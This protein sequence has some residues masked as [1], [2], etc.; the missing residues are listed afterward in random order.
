MKW[1]A[2]PLLMVAANALAAPFLVTDPLDP[3]ATSCGVYMDAAAKVTIPVGLDATGKPIC[4]YDLVSVAVGS[5]T[6]QLTAMDNDPIWG[7][8]ESAK[9][10]PF[11]F[12]RPG[13]LPI[14]ANSRLS[15]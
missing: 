7:S 10:A 6:V 3:A 1:L 12:S 9:S 14:P 13:T 5:H 2:A 8:R 4:K 11:A 15:P